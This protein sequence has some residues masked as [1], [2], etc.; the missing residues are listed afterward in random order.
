MVPKCFPDV[1]QMSINVDQI[2]PFGIEWLIPPPRM[3]S[4][5]VIRGVGIRK[6]GLKVSYFGSLGH[7]LGELDRSAT[8]TTCM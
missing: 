8:E 2:V 3:E 1:V 7:Y 4:G 6:F 5:E